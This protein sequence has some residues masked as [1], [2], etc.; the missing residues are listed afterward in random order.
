M[1]YKSVHLVA[2][3][4]HQRGSQHDATASASCVAPHVVACGS[5][6]RICIPHRCISLRSSCKTLMIVVPEMNFWV[7]GAWVENRRKNL[8]SWSFEDFVAYYEVKATLK[9][10]GQ[11]QSTYNTVLP[12]KQKNRMEHIL[13]KSAKF[14]EPIGYDLFTYHHFL[15]CTDR[16]SITGIS[17]KSLRLRLRCRAAELLH[18]C[19]EDILQVLLQWDGL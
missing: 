17:K 12:S 6:E 3:P 9:R 1:K 7:T 18:W 8:K 5:W 4:S 19:F 2:W 10:T 15:F 11:Y 16:L 13:E 14:G